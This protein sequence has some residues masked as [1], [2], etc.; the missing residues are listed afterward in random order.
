VHKEND[1]EITAAAQLV[2]LALTSAASTLPTMSGKWVAPILALMVP[3]GVLLV[4]QTG[5]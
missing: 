2:V 5:L 3:K 4:V 1:A